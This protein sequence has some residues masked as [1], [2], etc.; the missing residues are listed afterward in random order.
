MKPWSGCSGSCDTVSRVEFSFQRFQTRWLNLLE[1]QDIRRTWKDLKATLAEQSRRS[2]GGWSSY[3]RA[4]P[5]RSE[6]YYSRHP[7]LSIGVLWSFKAILQL[8]SQVIRSATIYQSLFSW[9]AVEC[10]L[11]G[12]SECPRKTTTMIRNSSS[13]CVFAMFSSNPA[14]MMANPEIK[15]L[16]RSRPSLGQHI[17]PGRCSSSD[18]LGIK[19]GNISPLFRAFKTVTIRVRT[20]FASFRLSSD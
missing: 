6:I 17:K 9:N 15:E 5:E 11:S 16:Y 12:V 14:S 8:V 2:M 3:S 4:I 13:I 18:H 7:R 20:V 1:V 10:F 19:G